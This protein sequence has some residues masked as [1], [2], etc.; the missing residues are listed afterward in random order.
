[1]KD[2]LLEIKVDTSKTYLTSKC[3]LY[4]TENFIKQTK[5][6]SN[7]DFFISK[8]SEGIICNLSNFKNSLPSMVD[9][10][11]AETKDKQFAFLFKFGEQIGSEFLA[12][13]IVFFEC[14]IDQK[15]VRQNDQRFVDYIK[16]HS[17][18][19]IKIADAKRLTKSHDFAK[20]YNI[21]NKSGINLPKLSAQQKEIVETVDKN[22]LVQGVAGSGKTNIC[23]DKII[24]TACR[25]YSGSLLYT[26]YSR[27][28]LIDTKLKVESF[29]KE[30]DDF[31][32]MHKKGN[33]VFLDSDHK[34]ALE[35]KFGI[36]FFSED[37][38]KIIAKIKNII[39][40]LNNKVDYFLIED[41]YKNHTCKDVTL[42]TE[43]YF[44]NT[45]I[46]TLKNHNVAKGLKKIEK[47][48]AEILYKEINGMIFGSYDI[49]NPKPIISLD[50]YVSERKNSFLPS[51]C[52]A[53]YQVALDYKKHC[54]NKN[55]KDNNSIS[56]EI[57]QNIDSYK[58]YS[59][60][61]VDEVQDYSEV[62][63][64]MLKKLAL[65]L[66][67]VGDALQMIN[68]S[69]FSFGYLKN[70]LFDKDLTAVKELTHNFRS[71]KKIEQIIEKLTDINKKQF[72]THNFVI[73]GQSIESGIKTNAIYVS[74]ESFVK[75]I[76]N[77]SFDNFTFVVT[78]QEQK[79]KLKEVIKNQEILTVSEIK[80]LERGTVVLVNLLSDNIQKWRLLEQNNINHK[81]A[82]ENSVYRYYYNLFYVGVS[83]AKQNIFVIE[84]H[85]ISMFKDLFAEN[86]DCKTP[87]DAMNALT[88]IISKIE[89][90]EKELLERVQEFVRLEQFDNARFTANKIKDD[91]VRIQYLNTIYVHENFVQYGKYRDAG[92]KFWEYGMIDKAKEQFEISGDK[93]L[94]SLVDACSQNNNQGLNIDIVQYFEDVKDN[95]TARNFIVETVKRDLQN[96]KFSFKQIK[97]NFKQKKEGGKKHGK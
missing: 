74:D 94:I 36:Y 80:G 48:S 13:D 23:I 81:L 34:K 17:I 77:A 67:C 86:F 26:T 51:E 46:K 41:I 30:L 25:N 73:K 54:E 97:E 33:V 43:N 8:I 78:N 3:Q 44:V 10:Y 76:A 27:G 45:Y 22:I 56:K 75:M 64:C 9:C 91:K 49:N 85:N 83:R 29:A 90:T 40:Y 42:A 12:K 7:V 87:V 68:P 53:I 65:K 57:L 66:V 32:Q 95:T 21:S 19:N 47:Y 69:Y 88:A 4:K 35:N 82:D 11:K 52:E 71:T 58:K 79:S 89:F 28:L 38:D 61:I 93:N 24:F 6:I 92:I 14:L 62:N 70:L 72:G 37:D 5:Y 59:L 50:D 15:S 60:A 84:K 31:V 39:E 1:M 63:L 96:L 55:L 18:I 2:F 16:T 20:L